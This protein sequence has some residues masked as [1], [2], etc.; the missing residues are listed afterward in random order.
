MKKRRTLLK[1]SLILGVS[2][3]GCLRTS[4]NEEQSVQEDQTNES[5]QI[6]ESPDSETEENMNDDG[7]DI[8][9]PSISFHDPSYDL[10][11]GSQSGQYIDTIYTHPEF[12]GVIAASE[13]GAIGQHS[14]E[15]DTVWRDGVENQLRRTSIIGS[16]N[17]ETV[18]AH[19]ADSGLSVYAFDVESGEQFWQTESVLAENLSENQVTRAVLELVNNT[20]IGFF[21]V[22]YETTTIEGF[23]PKTGERL[24]VTRPA[25]QDDTYDHLTWG[26]SE[27]APLPRNRI[28]F[29]MANRMGSIDENGDLQWEPKIKDTI[30]G[31]YTPAVT[32][33][34]TVYL[35]TGS[36]LINYDPD[37]ERAI[38][39]YSALDQ[40]TS[41]I[42]LHDDV[43]LFGAEDNG[44]YAIDAIN[45]EEKWRF[46]TND[47]VRAPPVVRGQT[48]YIGSADQTIYAVDLKQG[49]EQSSIE[50]EG[51][52]GTIEFSGTTLY[53]GT[54]AG[55]YG[56]AVPE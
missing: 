53:V 28:L 3:S 30:S 54:E 39:K 8:T 50:L 19:V 44:V 16:Q 33:G 34:E 20:I 26:S 55:L 5:D 22:G 52:I 49:E 43:V 42:T 31:I 4:N 1:T 13:D 48:V 41:P 14:P 11:V 10:S 51:A 6:T 15:G 21:T 40:I 7:R 46:Q 23:A 45:G 24:W 2:M 17:G 18:L 9:E 37:S 25:K 47:Y 38:W 12:N 27:N 35:P 29:D 36:A 56:I 32:D